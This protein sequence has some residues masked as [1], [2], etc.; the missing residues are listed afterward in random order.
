[1]PVSA[2]ANNYSNDDGEKKNL[3]PPSCRAVLGFPAGKELLED[4]S[5]SCLEAL[6][7]RFDTLRT[8]VSR[9]A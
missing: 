3:S 5:R 8:T 6:L 1:M 4:D 9:Q 2:A 7:Q